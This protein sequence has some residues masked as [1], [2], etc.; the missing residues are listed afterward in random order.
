MKIKLDQ[1][2]LAPAV[3]Q[4]VN[5]KQVLMVGYVNPGSLRRT[6]EGG[7]VWFYSR[8]REEL[9]HK[10]EISGNFLNLKFAS[11]DCD[12]DTLLFQVAPDG[13]TCHTG[14]TSCFFTPLTETPRPEDYERHER[15]PGVLD[16]LF[17]VIQERKQAMPEGSYTTSL[18]KSGVPRIAQKVI[19]EGGEAA[20]AAATGDK[21]HLPQEAADLFYHALVLLAAAGVTPEDVW[22]VLRERR[23]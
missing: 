16:E 15:G 9:W 14:N 22:K 7:Q 13:P 18:F 12:G 6:L 10:G 17:A 4:D 19:E 8:S 23:R 21:E 3:V 5:T 2:G 11:V 20:L 1:R